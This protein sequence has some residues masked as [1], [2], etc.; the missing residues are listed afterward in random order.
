[1]KAYIII[2]AVFLLLLLGTNAL[3]AARSGGELLPLLLPAVPAA[4]LPPPNPPNPPDTVSV[5]FAEQIS[6]LM[7]DTGE[8]LTLSVQ[9]YLV[10]C[11]FAQIS[12]SYHEQALT[13]QAIVAHTYVLRLLHDGNNISDNPATCQPFLREEKARAKFAAD[14]DYH[15]ALERFR[16]AARI[17]STRAIVHNAAPSVPIY[18]VYHSLSAGVT[19]TAF[20]VW[21]IDLPYLQ[22]VDSSW[23]R[24]H[25]E[26]IAV[27]EI[28]SETIRLAMFA[29]NRTA[30]MPPDYA[31]WFASPVL[32]EFGYVISSNVGNNRLSGGDL[33]R[34][35]G[36]R[37]VAFDIT[38]R[39][40]S[41][42]QVFIFET[43]GHGHGVGLS[44][45]GADV[46]AR[47]GHSFNEILDYYYTEV[48]IRE[49]RLR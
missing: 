21:G 23:D 19:N 31:D 25:P 42:A 32:S 14:A 28:S 12:P 10:G 34:A 20:P 16:A 35:L 38:Q 45:Y 24:E 47:R 30:S 46:L 26:F 41:G 2:I 44:Q 4:S 9:D 48:Q 40:M 7:T 22:S 27:N 43:R 49:N 39:D 29:F 18:S 8:V 3:F 33:W 6:V 13:A 36:L 37:S 15:N 1:M 17:A 11:L 5:Q